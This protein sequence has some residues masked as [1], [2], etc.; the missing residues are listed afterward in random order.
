MPKTKLFIS[1]RRKDEKAS[2]VYERLRGTYGED[3]VFFDKEKL[4]TGSNWAEVLENG[5]KNCDAVIAIIGTYW[6]DSSPGGGLERLDNENDWVRK[7]LELAFDYDKRIFPVL[8]DV[9]SLPAKKFLPEKLQ[10]LHDIQCLTIDSSQFEREVKQ[11]LEDLEKMGFGVQEETK[12]ETGRE[13]NRRL[14]H[15]NTKKVRYDLSREEVLGREEELQKLLELLQ[16]SRNLVLV[17]GLGGIGKTTL[18]NYYLS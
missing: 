12:K 7:E 9:K 16:K 4:P 8:L 18:V 6:C 14:K 2:P 1:Y 15:L 3:L 11:L 5:V 10:E 13:T 17:S